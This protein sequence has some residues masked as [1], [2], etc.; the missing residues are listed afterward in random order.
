MDEFFYDYKDLIELLPVGVIYYGLSLESKYMNDRL[1]EIDKYYNCIKLLKDKVKKFL[2]SKDIEREYK[3]EIDNKYFHVK[4]LKHYIM[5]KLDGVIVTID[6]VTFYKEVESKLQQKVQ[7]EMLKVEK[8]KTFNLLVKGITHDFNNILTVI[9]A[10]LSL[11]KSNNTQSEYISEKLYEIEKAANQGKELTNQLLTFAKKQNKNTEIINICE[12]V[13]DTVNMISTGLNVNCRYLFSNKECYININ[14]GQMSQVIN[15]VIINASQAMANGGNID[16]NIQCKSLHDNEIIFLKE[17][18]YIV[19]SIKDY[20]CGIP[21]KNLNLIFDPYFTTKENG[22]GLG[23][24]TSYSIIRGYGGCITVNSQ[25]GFGTEFNIFL[26][27]YKSK[28]N[29][30]VLYE[31]INIGINKKVNKKILLMDDLEAI[32]EVMCLM[33]SELGY[34]VHCCENGEQAIELY[35]KS[36]LEEEYYDLVILDLFVGESYEGI[37]VGKKL[38]EIDDKTKIILTSGFVDNSVVNNYGEYGFKGV[39]KKPFTLE[40]LSDVIDKALQN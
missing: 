34:E 38:L 36:C 25:V 24:A 8:F 2:D 9:L 16:I 14:K 33:I 21:N 10:N 5:G 27:E 31:N 30:D 26:P 28:K 13:R 32:R 6:D 23:L 37:N 7:Q 1:I 19:I 40:Q 4:F 29:I 20:G 35:S 11:C 17:G 12:F 22:N 3:K 18:N 15:N 39:I